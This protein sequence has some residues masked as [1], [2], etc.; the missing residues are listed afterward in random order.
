M[1]MS[2]SGRCLLSNFMANRGAN[3]GKC[4]HSCRW[5]YKLHLRLKDG[6]LKEIEI[7]ENN[8]DLFDFLIQ[9]EHRPGDALEIVEF[10]NMSHIL[11]SKDLCLL[12]KLPDFINSLSKMTASPVFKDFISVRVSL[13]EPITKSQLRTGSS[14][15][16]LILGKEVILCSIAEKAPPHYKT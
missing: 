11:N 10:E 3:Q 15:G 16:T 2:Y 7:N 6:S 8:K 13:R 9:E 5:L 14:S 4:A 12:P 1:C